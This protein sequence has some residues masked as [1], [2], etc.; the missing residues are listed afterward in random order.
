MHTKHFLKK[1]NKITEPYYDEVCVSPQNDIHQKAYFERLNKIKKELLKARNRGDIFFIHYRE[2]KLSCHG[3]GQDHHRYISQKISP[4]S[5][6]T[7]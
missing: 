3:L 4:E 1:E 2:R 5:G 6:R 7:A